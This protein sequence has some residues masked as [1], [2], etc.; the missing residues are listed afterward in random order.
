MKKLFL[1]FIIFFIF[2]YSSIFSVKGYQVAIATNSLTKSEKVFKLGSYFMLPF[3]EKV[4]YINL[5]HQTSL[6]STPVV[7]DK[8][9]YNINIAVD[10]YITSPLQYYNYIKVNSETDVSKIISLNIKNKLSDTLTSVAT[11][12]ELNQL[13][14]VINKAIYIKDLGVTINSATVIKVTLLQNSITQTPPPTINNNTTS[15]AINNTRLIESAYY[16]SQ[17]IRDQTAIEEAN[18]YKS[19]EN[20][21]PRFYEYFR[22][23]ETYKENSTS[24]EDIPPLDKLY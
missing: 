22:K 11:L 16:I 17:K 15:P 3:I 23:L 14:S 19:I 21:D 5:N 18:L 2:L 20:K 6:L 8:Q 4:T 9:N 24:K 10:W 1:I 12:D 13:Q 7:V